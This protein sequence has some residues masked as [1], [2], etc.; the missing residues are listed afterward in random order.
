MSKVTAYISTKDRYF[1]SLLPAIQSIAAQTR[2]P[3]KFVLFDDG[4]QKDLRQELMYSYVFA[5]MEARG[6][7][8]EVRFGQRKGQVW[9]HEAMLRSAD[10]D[11]IWRLDDD[12]V[13]DPN[14]LEKLVA[15]L[16]HDKT[17]GAVGSLVFIPGMHGA[18]LESHP[19]L[20]SDS[21]DNVMLLPNMQWFKFNGIRGTQH[22]HNTFLYRKSAA[23]GYCLDL[24]PV[25][26]REETLFTY[27][28]YNNGFDIQVCGDCITWHCRQP[29]GGIRADSIHRSEA[30]DHDEA[31]FLGLMKNRYKI[32]VKNCK[33]MVL[34]AG[35]GDHLVFKAV[36]PEILEKYKD[37]KIYLACCNPDLF[38]EWPEIVILS[39][40]EASLITNE[41]DHNIYKW[42]WDRN[43]K[44]SLED[45]Y[46][47]L[48]LN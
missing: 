12:N 40:H 34:N 44:G 20:Y 31:I 16:D 19:N 13:A 1:T 5:I 30:F 43:W 21:I 35:I 37:H 48:Y 46:R 17:V 9:N 26:H 8:W 2:P 32:D 39:I 10:T 4:A 36:L 45:A 27:D 47:G 25:G 22:L 24:S 15:I 11:Y 23:R 7:K 28:I 38:K 14:V 42:M 18:P 41:P 33:L 29:S 6:I 3:D